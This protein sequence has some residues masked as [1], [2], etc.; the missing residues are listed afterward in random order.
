MGAAL[1]D[2][3]SILET[4]RNSDLNVVNAIFGENIK[5]QTS[6]PQYIIY[7]DGIHLYDDYEQLGSRVTSVVPDFEVDDIKPV[8]YRRRG[9]VVIEVWVFVHP[10]GK[11]GS[12]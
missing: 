8:S 1:I 5:A 11:R 10:K 6:Y 7:L 9:R 2:R 3:L 4:L 12:P